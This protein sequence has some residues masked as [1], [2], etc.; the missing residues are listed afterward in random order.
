MEFV[1]NPQAQAVRQA[2]RKPSAIHTVLQFRTAACGTWRSLGATESPSAGQESAIAWRVL[3]EATFEV[4]TTVLQDGC[5]VPAGTYIFRHLLDGNNAL[6]RVPARLFGAPVLT[7][8][9]LDLDELEEYTPAT[10]Q[11]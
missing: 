9:A 8:V 5:L 10:A 6:S 3:H 2:A 11:G 4:G 1:M 7:T